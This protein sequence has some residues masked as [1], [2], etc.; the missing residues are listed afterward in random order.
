MG[1]RRNVELTDANLADGRTRKVK[2]AGKTL[3]VR[4]RAGTNGPTL[5]LSPSPGSR[6]VSLF[7]VGFMSFWW[8]R[9]GG[10]AM[11]WFLQSIRAEL[12]NPLEIAGAFVVSAGVSLIYVLFV[13]LSVRDATWTFE[14]HRATRRLNVLGVPVRSSTYQVFDA[15]D[16]PDT[17][18]LRTTGAHDV[19]VHPSGWGSET[20]DNLMPLEL[21]Q[22]IRTH[23]AVPHAGAPDLPDAPISEQP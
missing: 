5:E 20:D 9:L 16:R 7:V 2:W 1:N 17:L 3:R 10:G 18:L 14:P 11:S 13:W 22:L 6:L 19:A 8:L 15:V 23:L 21:R 4:V 12:V